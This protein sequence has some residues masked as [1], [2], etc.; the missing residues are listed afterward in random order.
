MESKSQIDQLITYA[1]TR[2]AFL[3]LLAAHLPFVVMY[4]IGLWKQQTHYQFFPFALGAF[5]VLYWQ[6]RAA[7]NEV[8]SRLPLA[9]IA[10]DIASMAL[11]AWISSPW[12]F[13]FGLGCSLLA[14][15]MVTGDQGYQRS[16]SYLA[17]LPLLTIR[18]PVNGDLQVIHGLQSITT[19]VASKS[20]QRFGFLHVRSGNVLDFPGKRF[21]VEEACSGVQSLF[22]I[23]FVAALIICVQRRTLAHGL[24]L[25]CSGVIFAGLMN[26]IRVI[27]IAVAWDQRGVDLS[28]GW[29]HDAIGYCCLGLAALLLL[30]A[31]SFLLFITDVVP[32][33]RRPG[34][35][36]AF[37]NPLIAVWNFLFTVRESAPVS[38]AL[39]PGAA[40]AV[41]TSVPQRR[42]A[43]V[44]TVSAVAVCGLLLTA[45]AFSFFG[46]PSRTSVPAE[47]PVV[48]LTQEVLPA[49]LEGYRLDSWTTEASD[50]PGHPG[51]NSSLWTYGRD[52]AGVRV[53]C[54]YPFSGWHS[55]HGDYESKDWHINSVELRPGA[56][57]WDAVIVR[58]AH[59][60][61]GR[62]AVL[63]YSMFNQAGN[64]VVP[65]G[66]GSTGDLVL[67][68]VLSAR[69]AGP[70]DQLT[71]TCQVFAEATVAPDEQVTKNLIALHFSSRDL[72]RKT[73]R[74]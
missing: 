49:T 11:G 5:A 35:V 31:D 50:D 62:Y 40:V 44:L 71:Y 48:R 65:Q 21:L 29:Q 10:V 9:L 74:R 67:Q 68:R 72:L 60:A 33:V 19:T 39:V 42:S 37:R 64:P 53:S 18:L 25:L 14:L 55:L 22:T 2:A 57:S 41:E 52:G 23:L 24:V 38:A 27:T 70:D 13:A 59:T 7:A 20:L 3:L 73:F 30:S 69:S 58:M 4:Y 56:D 43:R 66:V 32:D 51:A 28:T 46:G 1:R 54:D 26:V 6:R 61:G 36:G 12:L 34:P 47:P 63:I 8:W 45:Q 16:L 17:L 15:C